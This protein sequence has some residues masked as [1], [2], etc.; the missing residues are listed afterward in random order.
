VLALLLASLTAASMLLL[1]L[2]PAPLDPLRSLS[3]MDSR[4]MDEVFD[5]PAEFRED[6][7][8][9]IYIHHSKAA[10]GNAPGNMGDHFLIGNGNGCE[11]GRI[12]IGPLW[13]QQQPA[14]PQGAEVGSDCISICLVGDFDRR[15]PTDRQMQRLSRL[16][17]A[18]QARCRISNSQ[19]RLTVNPADGAGGIGSYFP[20]ESFLQHLAR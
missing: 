20:R 2:S 7:W 5:T 18:I 17:A 1:A 12:H 10:S 11:D 4:P 6:R 8:R 15:P 19:L 14:H 16:V 9:Y 3:A 13:E